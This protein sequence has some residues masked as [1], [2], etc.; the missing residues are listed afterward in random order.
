MYDYWVNKIGLTY[1]AFTYKGCLFLLLNTAEKQAA[2]SPDAIGSG[3]NGWFG[4]TQIAYVIG[5][6][7][8][9]KGVR[10]T[11]V[12][13]HKP[14]W[15]HSDS[16]WNRIEAALSGRK[17]TVFAGHYHNLTLHTRNDY[18]Y[19]VLGATGAGFTPKQTKELGSFDHYSI[20]TIDGADVT[21]ALV[22]PGNVYPANIS[23][24]EFKDKLRDLL[25][26]RTTFNIDRSQ[27]RSTGTV[28]VKLKNELEKVTKVEVAFNQTGNWQITPDKISLEIPPGWEVSG[29]VELS[30]PSNTLTP[31]PTYHYAIIYGGEQLYGRDVT[32]NP[33][34]PDDLHALKDWM[35]VG[36]FEL[37]TTT[38]PAGDAKDPEA[39]LP[40][41]KAKLGPELDG[42]IDQ[43]YQGKDGEIG[44]QEYH[45]QGE[46]VDLNQAFHEPDWAIGYGVAYIKS[47]D[48]RTV[49]AGIRG[50]D[51]TR[52]FVN[53]VEL[54]TQ[55]SASGQL[56]YIDL[57][58]N[59]GWN[60]VM[61]KCA[62]YADGWSYQL[63][64]ENPKDE[65]VFSHT[66]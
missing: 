46:A 39:S 37:G 42:A 7:E 57:P 19:F 18:R 60:T 23:T 30:C 2:L 41:F 24:A 51:V 54:Y 31:F 62:D 14:A 45:A 50:D 11:F 64:V 38:K 22:E 43:K 34:K 5:E 1:Y 55:W 59:E 28:A 10:H 25:T 16:D 32:L 17:Y 36:P 61:V 29:S 26:Y 6:L 9:N 58:L 40:N 15:L 35:I 52:L 8:K 53:G 4:E 63:A 21:V 49:F 27:P 3:A 20:V 33:I 65:L 12:F 48:K 44:W 56:V 66:K 47:P 13:M